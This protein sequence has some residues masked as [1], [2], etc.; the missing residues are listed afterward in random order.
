MTPKTRLPLLRSGS[1]AARSTPA[2][3]PGPSDSSQ[4][5]IGRRGFAAALAGGSIL[6]ARSVAAGTTKLGGAS[7][8]WRLPPPDAQVHTTACAYCVVGCGYKAYTWPVDGPSGGPAAGD[9]A[10]GVDFPVAPL[11]GRWISPEMYNQVTLDGVPH[12]IVVVPDADTR[13]VNV[14][15]DHG[16]GGSLAQ[17]LFSPERP[18]DRLLQPQLRV[19]ERLLPISWE[20]AIELIAAISTHILERFGPLAWGMKT[21]SYQ[22]YENTYAITKLAFKA[23]GTPCWAPHDKP[24]EASDTPGLSDAGID[25]FSA[26][27]Q[28]WKES[29]VLFVSGVSL[30]DAHQILFTQWVQRGPK[31]IVVGP[32]RDPTAEYAVRNDGLFLQI[33]P[34]TDTLLHNSIAYVILV[35]GWEDREFIDAQCAHADQLAETQGTSWRRLAFGVDPEG[36]RS[37]ILDDPRHKPES[38]AA[39]VGISPAEIR[40]AAEMLAGPRADGS[41]VKASLMF[42]KGNYWGHNYPGT[43]SLASLGLLLG[44]GNRPGRVVSR[45]GGHQR[46]MVMA[47]SYPTSLSPH[48]VRGNKMGV[49]LDHWAMQGELRFAWVIGCTWAGGGTAA[50]Q[51]LFDSLRRQARS[52][53]ERLPEE[54]ELFP[55]G[56]QGELD[57]AVVLA[58]WKERLDAGGMVLLHQDLYS[59]ALSDLADLILPAAG[60]GE[61]P[62]NRMQGER[63]LRHY[64]KIADP[65]GQ[66]KPDWWVIAEVARRMGF[67]GFDWQ[68]GNQVF[69]EA[70]AATSGGVN[71][72]SELVT[73]AQ[74]QG[75]TATSLIAELGTTGIQCPIKRD[76]EEL[77]GTVRLH[78]Q[79]FN[80]PTKKALFVRGSW[81]DVEPRQSVAQPR[82]GELWVVNRRTS[83]T[84]S[85]MVEDLR[86]PYRLSLYPENWIE[87]HP[88]DA[89]E[90]NIADGDRITIETSGI[91]AEGL[92]QGGPDSKGA[93]RGIARISSLVRPGTCCAYFNYLGD[94]AGAANNVVQNIEDPINLLYSFKLGRGRVTRADVSG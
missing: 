80:T 60:W 37:F 43:A 70:A 92:P 58:S 87:I 49:N 40:R 27:Y 84:W 34:G 19:G 46:G 90:R 63:R 30:Y 31:L 59:Q 11:S 81:D 4:R 74:E 64:S 29:E 23:I 78:E 77:V 3:E 6:A 94:P 13:V 21:Y 62:F 20:S 89:R 53:V 7:T 51:P 38:A 55:D 68:D 52:G 2:R 67:S 26:A 10:F 47:T 36:Y 86:M 85:S 88:E 28:D 73:L 71:D 76:G 48:S 79:G 91:V 9:N 61:A 41:R 24:R 56:E 25:A 66:A 22:F 69:E 45:A 35:N 12:H 72:Y 39:V 15:G 54:S 65:P 42:E 8:V 14:G 57:T 44:A 17:K 93:M 33:V 16:I 83:G 5:A 18:S 50:A 32:R 75:R 1:D 82:E